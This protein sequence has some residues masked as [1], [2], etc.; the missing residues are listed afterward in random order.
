MPADLSTVVN[1][2]Q[3]MILTQEI[4]ILQILIT[5]IHERLTDFTRK[6]A[7][8]SRLGILCLSEVFSIQV[9]D[10]HMHS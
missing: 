4:S 3:H 6:N 10:L 8:F 2:I 9:I 5:F 1:R 7:R